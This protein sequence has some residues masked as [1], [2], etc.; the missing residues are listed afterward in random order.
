VVAPESG[1]GRKVFGLK[2]HPFDDNVF[3]TGGWD[4]CLKVN[5]SYCTIPTRTIKY[6]L[7]KI[8]M[9]MAE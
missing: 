7:F 6:I 5:H 8:K 4:R 3:L 1:H 9:S 2:F